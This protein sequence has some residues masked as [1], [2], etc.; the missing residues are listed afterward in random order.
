MRK[1]AVIT[2]SVA[3][4]T[5]EQV[6]KYDIGI[7]P[8]FINSQGKAY[9]DWVDLTPGDAYKLFQ[10]NPDV[11]T[12]SAPSPADYLEFYKAASQKTKAIVVVTLS[13]KIS[14]TYNSAVL[15]GKMALKELP[16]VEISIIDSFTATA[17]EGFIALA[18][19]REA[20]LG[21]EI[22]DVVTV[23]NIV[24]ERVQVLVL[25][26]TIKYVYRSGRV[27]K[28]AAQAG[29]ML[30]IRPLLN[31]SGG[32]NFVSL[33]RNRQKGID[34]M[35]Q[36]IKDKTEGKSPHFAVMHAY[37]EDAAKH[38]MERISREFKYSELWLSEFSPIMG[39]ACG[40]GTLAVAYYCDE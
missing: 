34:M 32:V 3:C 15:A 12:T 1:V 22:G 17:A 7:V 4:L 19:A 18:A 33:A 16:G 38:L 21:K 20:E 36:K 25:L 39:Y 27:P 10:N 14:S 24:K 6:E 35:L 13:T 5:R 40:T 23:A 30:N 26:D 8:L 2:D 29:S 11:F 9:R 28:I 31:V 37:A